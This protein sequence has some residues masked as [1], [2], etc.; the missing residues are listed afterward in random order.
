[1]LGNVTEQAPAADR[2][3]FIGSIWQEICLLEFW[4]WHITLLVR[5]VGGVG[6]ALQGQLPLS[7]DGRAHEGP[8]LPPS[9][10]KREITAEK[11]S[12]SLPA[13]L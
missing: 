5:R 6:A 12:L 2:D 13:D 3:T 8:R 7:P 9:Q 1:M 4:I 11:V 10:E